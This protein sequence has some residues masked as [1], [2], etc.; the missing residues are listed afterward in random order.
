LRPGTRCSAATRAPALRERFHVVGAVHPNPD[1][2]LIAEFF[3]ECV[4]FPAGDFFTSVRTVAAAIAAQRPALILYLGVGMASAVIALASL[5]LAPIQCASFGHTA[6]TM[7]HYFVLPED[8]VGS[9]E[10]FSE[11]ILAVPKAA[12]PF[13]PQP[14]PRDAVQMARSVSPFLLQR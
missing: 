9:A 6:S 1:S 12:M 5:R 11:T 13:A 3:D 10:C 8:F 7:S 2:A 4:A 14:A